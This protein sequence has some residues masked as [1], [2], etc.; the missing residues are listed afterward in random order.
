MRERHEI[1]S[2]K[3]HSKAKYSPFDGFT[4]VGKAAKTI[5]SGKLVMED[6][7][8]IGKKGDGSI[9]GEL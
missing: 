3:F 1:D 6:G 5:V 4:C 2:A 7:E 9:I 8:I